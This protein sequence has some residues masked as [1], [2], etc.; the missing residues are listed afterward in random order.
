MNIL[1]LQYLR[2]SWLF[3]WNCP[4]SNCTKIKKNC[5]KRPKT[6]HGAV[7]FFLILRFVFLNALNM[8]MNKTL[9]NM[10]EQAFKTLC[11]KPHDIDRM[12]GTN[13]ALIDK[14]L[15]GLWMRHTR[16]ITAFMLAMQYCIRMKK[17]MH[18]SLF[19][20]FLKLKLTNWLTTLNLETFPRMQYI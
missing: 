15:H 17:L 12:K 20:M 11:V 3:S 2:Y 19:S 5:I 16:K 10:K 18:L 6:S 8:I 13:R 1:I 9:I 7:G 14:L 4:E